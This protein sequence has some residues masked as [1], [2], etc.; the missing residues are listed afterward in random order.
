[1]CVFFCALKGGA[2]MLNKAYSQLTAAERLRKLDV[3]IR[4]RTDNLLNAEQIK[5]LAKGIY[6]HQQIK[7]VVH[8]D[9]RESC[10]A[11]VDEKN[12][13]HIYIPKQLIA[14]GKE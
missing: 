14:N 5:A 6:F 3:V 10:D 13:L 8:P 9:N 1:M 7:I 4:S 11:L 2:F 12:V